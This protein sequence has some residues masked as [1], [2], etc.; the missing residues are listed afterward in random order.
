M[1]REE[2]V[3]TMSLLIF[4]GIGILQVLLIGIYQILCRIYIILKKG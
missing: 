3:I 4:I 2:E 1:L